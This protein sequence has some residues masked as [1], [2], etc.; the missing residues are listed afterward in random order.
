MMT[1][2]FLYIQGGLLNADITAIHNHIKFIPLLIY[3]FVWANSTFCVIDKL[4]EH[5][6]PGFSLNI[7]IISSFETRSHYV[8]LADLELAV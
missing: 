4:L 1:L 2:N 7:I 6:C 5:L 8:V 3:P